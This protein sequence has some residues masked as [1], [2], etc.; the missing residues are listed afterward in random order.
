A[1]LR[2]LGCRVRP[3]SLGRGADDWWSGCRLRGMPAVRSASALDG[4]FDRGA[5]V[6][7]ALV[8]EH[9]HCLG[10]PDASRSGGPACAASDLD[11]YL[12]RGTAHTLLLR[13]RLGPYDAVATTPARAAEAV[14][15]RRMHSGSRPS[16]RALVRASAT[17]P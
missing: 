3:D 10:H 9:Q 17:K 6:L 2:C 15:V 7:H 14:A 12:R 13:L 8:L 5:N 4:L 11:S 1:F 16:D